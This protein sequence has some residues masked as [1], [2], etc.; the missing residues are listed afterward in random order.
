MSADTWKVIACI[1]VLILT[2]MIKHLMP[3]SKYH[4]YL[5]ESGALLVFGFV[6]GFFLWLSDLDVNFSQSLFWDYVLPPIIFYAGYSMKRRRFF[7]NLGTISLYGI[8]GTILS[9]LFFSVV[10]FSFG[11][12]GDGYPSGGLGKA[13]LPYLAYGALMT[14]TDSVSVLAILDQERQPLT[15]SLVFGEGVLNDAISIVLFKTFTHIPQ[16]VGNL[17]LGST[18]IIRFAWYLSFSTALGAGAGLLCCVVVRRAGIGE[19][20]PQLEVLMT[21]LFAWLSYMIGEVMQVSPIVSCFFCGIVLSHY[22]YYNMAAD[23]RLSFGVLSH[24]CSEAAESLT[25]FYIGVTVCADGTIDS[26]AWDVL[27]I[28]A[29][30]FALI[31]SR[32]LAIGSLSLIANLCFLQKSDGLS[33]KQ[34]LVVWYSG[35]VRGVVAFALALNL[36]PYKD[37][38][39]ITSQQRNLALTSTAVVVVFTTIIFGT[40]SGP[41]LQRFQEDEQIQVGSGNEGASCATRGARC[42]SRMVQCFKEIDE[43]LLQRCFG[44]RHH[45]RSAH[46]EEMERCTW[47]A[48]P[49]H[50]TR[51][52]VEMMPSND[53]NVPLRLDA[54][55]GVPYANIHDVQ[56]SSNI[57]ELVRPQPSNF[58]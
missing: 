11:Q 5:H 56:I 44:G 53:L 46:V 33:M 38:L 51:S 10:V 13:F 45:S 2:T 27:F 21:F 40:L 42:S 12:V 26:P 7:Q 25:F 32:G 52:Q 20:H 43:T 28:L 16:G 3:R 17:E 55:G 6:C 57:S 39:G 49:T 23:A 37:A 50:H 48:S 36:E 58:R 35:L 14:A 15:Y 1:I 54:D 22:N 24:A 4:K 18:M 9:T 41:F 31:V 30:I 8:F 29:A 34:V 19:E 47:L